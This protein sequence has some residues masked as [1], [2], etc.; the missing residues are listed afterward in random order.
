MFVTTPSTSCTSLFC[1]CMG[2]IAYSTT[3]ETYTSIVLR[4]FAIYS[5][6]HNTK[7]GLLLK[8]K[9]VVLV[10]FVVSASPATR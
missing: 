3:L 4:K 8:L 2:A 1:S 10:L 6:S 5:R 7:F 9:P